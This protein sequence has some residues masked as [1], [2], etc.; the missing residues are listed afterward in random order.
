MELIETG[1]VGDQR[2]LGTFVQRCTRK[3]L[4]ISPSGL[5]PLAGIT[6]M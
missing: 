1:A 4:A 5:V 3:D 6:A 2:P